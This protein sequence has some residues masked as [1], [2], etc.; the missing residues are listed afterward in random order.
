MFLVELIF[1]ILF[2]T[3]TYVVTTRVHRRIKINKMMQL[4]MSSIYAKI[5]NH[6][7]LNS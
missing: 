3:C 6:K 7:L 5:I 1:A 2:N 4:R